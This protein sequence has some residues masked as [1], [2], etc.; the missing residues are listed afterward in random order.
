VATTIREVLAFPSIPV[1]DADLLNRVDEVDEAAASTLLKPISSRAQ[2]EQA[3][4]SS[5][6]RSIE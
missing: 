1:I 4:A 6:I 2:S 5:P 3:W